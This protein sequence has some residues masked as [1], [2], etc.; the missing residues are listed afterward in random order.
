MVNSFKILNEA[1]SGNATHGADLT[2]RSIG[3]HEEILGI[4]DAR[5]H[6][7]F[8]KGHTVILPQKAVQMSRADMELGGQLVNGQVVAFVSKDAVEEQINDHVGVLQLGSAGEL[9]RFLMDEASL[10]MDEEDGKKVLAVARVLGSLLSRLG[11]DP[12]HPISQF[13]IMPALVVRKILQRGKEG[14]FLHVFQVKAQNVSR[15]SPGD[16]LLVVHVFIDQKPFARVQSDLLMEIH[17][18]DCGSLGDIVQ[19]KM[20]VD[21]MNR[22]LLF[23]EIRHLVELD[24]RIGYVYGIFSVIDLDFHIRLLFS[25]LTLV[26]YHIDSKKSI[27]S[28]IRN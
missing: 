22:V 19:L 7:L 27:L 15:G 11:E 6:K 5:S 25:K 9:D 2:D 17:G 23:R 4:L 18:V 14:L 16:G 28:L 21:M 8:V 20:G 3:I 13:G 1:G 24:I 26:L 12:C 10:E